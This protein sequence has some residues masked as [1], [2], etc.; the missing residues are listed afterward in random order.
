MKGITNLHGLTLY[1][2]LS[3]SELMTRVLRFSIFCCCSMIRRSR[4]N[5]AFLSSSIPSSSYLPTAA[6]QPRHHADPAQP[7]LPAPFH[8][9]EPTPLF[10]QPRHLVD[11]A[12]LIRSFINSVSRFI[13]SSAIEPQSFLEKIRQGIERKMKLKK[14]KLGFSRFL[15]LLDVFC[16]GFFVS[17]F[18][19]CFSVF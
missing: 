14:M 6:N 2:F 3:W 16:D 7:S 4:S 13:C 12:Q 19:I 9:R 8:H 11:L 17:V 1:E 18:S 5:C 15:V 10:L